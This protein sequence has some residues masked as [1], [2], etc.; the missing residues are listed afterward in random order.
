MQVGSGDV[1]GDGTFHVVQNGV[2]LGSVF[3]DMMQAAGVNQIAQF[4]EV[5]LVAGAPVELRYQ[6][7]VADSL[8][9]GRGSYF[10][11]SQLPTSVSTLVANGTATNDQTALKYFD[12]GSTR[13]QWGQHN[14]G[15]LDPSTVTL[16]APFANAEY[17]VIPVCSSGAAGSC[18]TEAKTTTTFDID[19]ASTFATAQTWDWFAIGQKPAV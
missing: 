6:P 12:V 8:P 2:S 11:V 17:V 13:Y 15:N 10:D 7:A 19:R 14:D 3:I 5:N 16:N 9:W 1:A 18:S 4:L